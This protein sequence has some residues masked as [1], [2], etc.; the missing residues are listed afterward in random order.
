MNRVICV[1]GS[2]T[3]ERGGQF[4]R[5]SKSERMSPGSVGSTVGVAVGSGVAVASGVGVAVGTGVDVGVAVG[6]VVLVAVVVGVL[7]AVAVGVR[8]AVSVGIAVAEGRGVA[9]AG[10]A[11]AGGASSAA[12]R[13]RAIGVL[14]T[15]GRVR[16]LPNVL[17]GAAGTAVG[18]SGG[19]SSSGR[20]V[21]EVSAVGVGVRVGEGVAIAGTTA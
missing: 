17:C 16:R 13:T 14:V 15:A 6:M 19:G 12:L 2:I 21:A 10:M 5:G 18:S 8:V 4:N 9:G 3:T 1:Q 7:V 11:V 20:L